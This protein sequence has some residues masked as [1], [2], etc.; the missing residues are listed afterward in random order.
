[1]KTELT[2][3]G[4]LRIIAD[5][6]ER[7]DLRAATGYYDREQIVSEG[8]HE[9]YDFIAPETIAALTDAPILCHADD[10]SVEDDGQRTIVAHARIYWFPNYA[11]TDPWEELADRGEVIFRSGE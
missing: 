3:R 7:E 8:L 1:M 4:D 5:E 6:D 10:T 11:I 2:A 9:H